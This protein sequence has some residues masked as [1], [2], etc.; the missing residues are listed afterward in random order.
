MGVLR[1]LTEHAGGA[2]NL[3]KRLDNRSECSGNQRTRAFH[4]DFG[5]WNVQCPGGAKGSGMKVEGG[6]DIEQVHQ[7][8]QVLYLRVF[9]GS[10]LLERGVPIGLET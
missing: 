10:D 5:Q 8:R 3:L 7:D 1:I 9:E 4:A 2:A 6:H